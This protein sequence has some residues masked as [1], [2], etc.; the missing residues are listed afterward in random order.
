M[1]PEA[2]YLVW[3]DC[4]GLVKLGLRSPS[5]AVKAATKPASATLTQFFEEVA[6]VQ[7]SPG[8]QF[9]GDADGHFQ[10]INIGCPRS[11]LVHALDRIQ[12]AVVKL[13]AEGPHDSFL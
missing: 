11:T 9:G 12:A 5:T 3:L 2:S 1:R 4:S 13:R 6:H 8:E 10:R 7:L